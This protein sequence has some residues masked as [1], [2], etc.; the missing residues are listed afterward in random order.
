MNKL[1]VY[2]TQ[3]TVDNIYSREQ[4]IK[5]RAML[6]AKIEMCTERKLLGI[7]PLP[8]CYRYT[9]SAQETI[10][11]KA[12]DIEIPLGE[13]RLT[14]ESRKRLAEERM[15]LEA[16]LNNKCKEYKKKYGTGR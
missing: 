16:W 15:H 3:I 13:Q 14:H 7:I 6:K 12:G 2:R 5:V 9:V 4:H 10:H 8:D 1:T 11:S